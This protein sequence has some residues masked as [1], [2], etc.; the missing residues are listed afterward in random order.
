[1]HRLLNAMAAGFVWGLLS[2]GVYW[3]IV[4]LFNLR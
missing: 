1:M 4:S 2:V 3:L